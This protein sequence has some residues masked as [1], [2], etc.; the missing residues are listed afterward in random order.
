MT[1]ISV[2]LVAL[3]S[4]IAAA[5]NQLPDLQ[6]IWRNFDVEKLQQHGFV[7]QQIDKRWYVKVWADE[8]LK[9][10]CLGR[11]HADPEHAKDI[12]CSYI[13]LLSIR[14]NRSAAVKDGEKWMSAV[15][16]KLDSA[17]KEQ[18]K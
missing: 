4:T 13:L 18:R 16:K 5:Q 12:P 11:I 1:A 3:L 8:S 17:R 15:Q 2:F 7:A 9:D 14:Q 6:D 10:D